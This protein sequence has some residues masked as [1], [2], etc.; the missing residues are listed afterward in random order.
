LDPAAAI[1]PEPAIV[2]GPHL[3]LLHLFDISPLSDPVSSKF[4]KA[5][6]DV[7]ARGRIGI[8]SARIIEDDRRLA[9]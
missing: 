9:A 5:A 3:A 2:L 1:G 6:H 7:D 4:G 8:G